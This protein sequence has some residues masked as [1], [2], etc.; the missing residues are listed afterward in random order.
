MY[1]EDVYLRLPPEEYGELC[2]AIWTINCGR[3]PEFGFL[4]YKNHYYEYNY[5]MV[6]YGIKITRKMDIDGN[7]EK[8]GARLRRF[9]NV[10]IK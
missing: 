2:H 6:D 1:R 3:I 5:S 7:E 4:L 9:R 8:I 10:R